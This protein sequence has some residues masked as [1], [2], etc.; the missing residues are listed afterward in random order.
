MKTLEK[1]AVTDSNI[2]LLTAD[3][4]FRLFDRFRSTQPDRF[5]NVGV[6]EANMIGIAA[7]LTLS[8]RNV[9]CYS[10]IPF[11]TMRCLE[12]IR[13]DLCYQNL[14]VKLLGAG[15]GLAYGFEG[16]T[17]HAVEDVSIM[18]SLPN[19]TVVVPGDSLEIEAIMNESATHRGPLYIRLGTD[20]SPQVH[21]TRPELKIGKGIVLNEGGDIGIIANGTMLHTAKI[22]SETLVSRGMAVTLISMPTV[23]P[24]DRGLVAECARGCRAIFTI[25]EHSIIGGLGSAVAEVLAEM[26]YRG[27]FRR[28]AIPD[29]Y[30]SD[31]GTAEYLREKCGLTP[32]VIINHILSEYEKHRCGGRRLP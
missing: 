10:I 30:G 7:G 14:D 22:V 16:M 25:E 23:K 17:H 29:A 11:L 13:V 31:I 8:G 26:G 19:M 24:L 9:Y 21:Q 18:R 20:G 6:A 4:G 5:V 15:G 27:L 1:L 12:Q 3:L 28:I 32:G 2:W